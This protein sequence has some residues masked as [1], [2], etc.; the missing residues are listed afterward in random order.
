MAFL[1]SDLFGRDPSESITALGQVGGWH[2]ESH[3]VQVLDKREVDPDLEGEILLE[4]AET[5]ERRRVFLGQLFDRER[6]RE[7]VDAFLEQIQQTCVSRK[8]SWCQWEAN[9]AYLEDQF[10]DLIGRTKRLGGRLADALLAPSLLV[11][12]ILAALPPL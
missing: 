6:Y 11:W 7:A 9:G 4:D 12:A 2:V 5:G 10:M 3:V 8:V 1:V